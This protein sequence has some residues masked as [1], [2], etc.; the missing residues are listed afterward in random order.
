MRFKEKESEVKLRS[1]KAKKTLEETP[2][3]KGDY[4]AMVIAAFLVLLPVIILVTI[5]FSII[6]WIMF[7]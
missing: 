2:P 3:E 4:L 5:I 7:T 1:E 6:I